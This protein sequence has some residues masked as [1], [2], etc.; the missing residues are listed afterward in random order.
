V[1]S[2][3]TGLKCCRLG[4]IPFG[5]C[6]ECNCL[7]PELIGWL[8]TSRFSPKVGQYHVS[9][10]AGCLGCAYV[11]YTEDRFLTP[12]ELWLMKRG[13]LLH[14]LTYAFK[15]RELDTS[16][17]FDF[18]GDSLTITAHLDAYSPERM[19]IYEFKT[20]NQ[21]DWQVRNGMVPRKAHLLQLQSYG[22][23]FRR[24]IPVM[25]L[26]L[27][28]LDMTAFRSYPV[29]QKD[30][31]PWLTSRAKALHEALVAKSGPPHEDGCFARKAPAE[32]LA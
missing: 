18:G 29:A 3:A 23:L 28:Y 17:A 32:A 31:L 25:S 26:N 14:G 8:G 19:A 20:T 5:E 13:S 12:S 7:P 22:S 4:N 2:V 9:S 24:I 21:L 27:V 11:G 15:W 1:T 6:G 10:L 16:Y 30:A